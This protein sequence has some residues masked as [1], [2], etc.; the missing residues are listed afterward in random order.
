MTTEPEPM[1]EP[2]PIP[3]PIPEPEP[4]APFN[5]EG[6]GPAEGDDE[7]EPSGAL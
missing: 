7:S 5:D 4:G 3:D 2:E 1:P 6:A